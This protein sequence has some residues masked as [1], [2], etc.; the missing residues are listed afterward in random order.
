MIEDLARVTAP[1]PTK[2]SK[3]FWAKMT[4]ALGA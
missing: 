2:R 1:A 4:E 3:G